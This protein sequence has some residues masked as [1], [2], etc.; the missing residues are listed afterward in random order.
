MRLNLNDI[1]NIPT[2]TIYNPDNFRTVS[3][4]SIDT[5]TIKKNSLYVAIKGAKHDGHR[6]IKDAIKKGANA[7]VIN[8]NTLSKFDNIKIPIITVKNTTK[9]LGDIAHIWR[10]KLNARIISITGSNGK[11]TTKEILVT[12]LSSKYNVAYTKAN[13]NNHIGVPITILS[14]NERHDFVILE[15]GTNHFNEIEYTTKIAEPDFAI[16]TNIGDSHL[17]Y[18]KNREGV[19]K[20]KSALF[21]YTKINDGIIFVNLDDPIIKQHSKLYKNKVTFGFK[22]KPK[23]KG[24]II[25]HTD[26]GKIILSVVFDKTSLNNPLPLY[27]E[28]NAKNFLAAITIALTLGLSKDIILK[29]IEKVK[30]IKGRLNIIEKSNFILIDDTYNA[31]PDSMKNA[32][33][34]LTKVNK[35][36]KKIVVLG[37]MFELGEKSK[38]IHKKLS[39][40]F[41]KNIDL[42]LTLGKY[43]KE[44]HLTLSKSGIVSRHFTNRK[45]L[46]SYLN[47]LEITNSVIL[48][49]GSRGMKMEEFINTINNKES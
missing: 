33:N 1:F 34:V 4:V 36:K 46:N 30:S 12:I 24:K 26:D 15:H 49:K 38:D 44:L 20:E 11:T 48:I 10:R 17:E 41:S 2:A 23:S 18:L 5:R 25:G 42:V 9:A 40:I 7:V 21:E 32:I 29:S 14:A 47:K 16:I 27:G 39:E 28:A 43:M 31:N 19:Y 37:D 6:F 35:Y 45:Q 8:K 3:S 13:N 22:N